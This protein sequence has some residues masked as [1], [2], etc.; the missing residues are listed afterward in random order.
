MK[1][2]IGTI[3]VREESVG[4][5]ASETQVIR[6]TV[7]SAG[8]GCHGGCGVDL[9]V[10]D[11]KLEKIEGVKDHP[12]NQGPFARARWRS[13]TMSTTRTGCKPR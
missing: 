2:P 8:A 6:S 3:N 7:W 5:N 13:R 10:R 1:Q 11:G 4:A 9:H 12:Y